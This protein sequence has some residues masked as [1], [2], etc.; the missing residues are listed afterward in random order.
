MWNKIVN[1]ETGRKVNV[2][3]KIGKKVLKN[4]LNNINGGAVKEDEIRLD[5]DGESFEFYKS[6]EEADSENSPGSE[7]NLGEMPLGAWFTHEGLLVKFIRFNNGG[8]G[9]VDTILGKDIHGN[10]YLFDPSDDA[11]YWGKW[12]NVPSDENH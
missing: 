11:I 5:E 7:F 4:Y 3:G 1:P 9:R 2:N 12:E 8:D 10:T 6:I